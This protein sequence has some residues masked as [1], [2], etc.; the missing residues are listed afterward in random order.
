MLYT[1]CSTSIVVPCNSG[2]KKTLKSKSPQKLLG[3]VRIFRRIQKI[4]NKSSYI[5]NYSREF[6][7]L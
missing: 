3:P 5:L 1:G 7:D 2:Y 4:K 6:K